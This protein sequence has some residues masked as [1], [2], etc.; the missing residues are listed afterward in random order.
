M[1]PTRFGHRHSHSCAGHEANQENR[2]KGGHIM[3]AEPHKWCD[4][5]RYVVT[6]FV[7]FTRLISF[8]YTGLWWLM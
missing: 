2:D 7:G 6:R 4:L 1:K 3:A 5:D 8:F